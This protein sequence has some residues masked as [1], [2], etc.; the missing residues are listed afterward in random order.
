MNT[1]SKYIFKDTVKTQFA[2]F[3]VLML[4]FMSQTFI[5]FIGRAAKGSIPAELVSQLMSLSIP[6]MANFMLP[7][8]LFL[9]LLFSIGSFCSQ[10]EMVVMRSVGYSRVRLLS[11]ACWMAFGTGLLSLA[12]T[13]V[14]SPWCEAKQLELIDKAKSDPSFFALESGKFLNLMDTVIYI[15]KFDDTNDKTMHQ[16]YIFNQ[17]DQGK[18]IAPSVTISSEGIINYDNNDLMWLSL[19]NGLRYEGPNKQNRF[20]VSEFGEYSALVPESNS[21]RDDLKVSAKSTMQL[22][23]DKSS[24]DI[25]ELQWRIAQ[26]ISIFVLVLLVVPLSMV[27]PRQGRFAKFL[28]AIAIYI[29]YY[30][31]AFGLKSSIAR[32]HFPLFPGVFLVPLM[33]FIIFSI[34]LNLTDTEWVRKFLAKYKI[35]RAVT[36]SK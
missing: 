13:T 18:N 24:A 4:I 23:K 12:C 14:L 30:L 19:K 7:L 16:I 3:A 15:D 10:S 29:S 26:P 32:E 17:G 11:I 33:Y 2:I 8:S 20:Q 9:A 21:V 28:P 6:S 22:Y 1:L 36:C 25:A 27:N 31:F 5:K 35:K 34:P